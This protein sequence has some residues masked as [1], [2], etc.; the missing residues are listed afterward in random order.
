[1]IS[2]H[3]LKPLSAATK[4]KSTK[5]SH[6]LR[7]PCN[8][9]H[10]KVDG[11]DRRIRLPLGCAE[12][13]FE[14]TKRLGHRTSGQTIQ[15][16]LTQAQP[17]VDAVLAS[18]S[19]SS[20]PILQCS[21]KSQPSNYEVNAVTVFPETQPSASMVSPTI[22]E[23]KSVPVLPKNVATNPP[24]AVPRSRP[25]LPPFKYGLES[26]GTE[27]SAEEIAAMFFSSSLESLSD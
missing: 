15:W 18:S 9:R 26:F 25:L 12:S 24:G 22:Y 11:R 4:P 1:M 27:F 8:D 23:A 2:S 5:H 13:V 7:K 6:G 19:S 10:L 16:L 14:L 20:P 21:V 3:S 17:A